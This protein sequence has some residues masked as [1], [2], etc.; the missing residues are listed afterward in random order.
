MTTEDLSGAVAQ[1]QTDG[2]VFMPGLLPADLMAAALD[3]VLAVSANHRA[4]IAEVPTDQVDDEVRFRRRQFDGMT[5]FPVPKCPTINR[6]FVH[7]LLVEFSQRALECEDLRLYQARIKSK[8]AGYTDYEQP[9]HLDANHSLVPI[10][11]GPPWGHVEMFVYLHDIDSSNGATMVAPVSGAGVGTMGP[12]SRASR[13]DR[14][15]LYEGEIEA[16]GPAG[17]VLAYRSDVWHRAVDMPP[18]SERHILVPAYRPAHVHWI[19][20]DPT[21]PVGASPAFVEFA[22]SCTPDDLALFG[23]P[24]PGHEF[25]TAE[26]L[27]SMAMLYDGLDLTPWRAAL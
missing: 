13:S 21:G 24:R 12:G 9:H 2:W 22:A 17:S 27:D 26:V 20:Y 19:G 10:R 14:P 3:E 11:N 15:E 1:W 25:W 6:L 16:S 4:A 18:G 23:V 7:P 5:L 8:Y